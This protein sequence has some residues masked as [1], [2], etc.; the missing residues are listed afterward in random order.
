MSDKPKEG[1]GRVTDADMAL[2]AAALF[3]LGALVERESGALMVDAVPAEVLAQLYAVTAADGPDEGE[4]VWV[5]FVNGVNKA[6]DDGEMAA[7]A[8]APSSG[9]VH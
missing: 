4:K 8:A 6:I 1:D 5:A 2:A 9:T 7:A 3:R